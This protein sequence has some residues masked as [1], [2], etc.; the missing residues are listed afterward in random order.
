LKQNFTKWQTALHETGWNSLYWNNHDQPRVVSRFGNDT[1]YR[2]ESAKM[3]ATLL[4]LLK[5]TPYIYQ[6]EEIGMT[7]VA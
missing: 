1:T 6:G 7:N 5:G 2:V 4:H 3:L